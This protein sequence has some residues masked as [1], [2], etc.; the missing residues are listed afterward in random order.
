M[1][2]AD[3]FSDAYS[4]WPN[5]AQILVDYCRVEPTCKNI[6]L[7]AC[8]MMKGKANAVEEQGK[9][10]A[11]YKSKYQGQCS[12]KPNQEPMAMRSLTMVRGLA[13]VEVGP[14]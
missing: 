12:H 7:A 14:C 13:V 4:L 3:L 8:I 9:A 1:R 11:I 2:H 10:R 5:G 6:V